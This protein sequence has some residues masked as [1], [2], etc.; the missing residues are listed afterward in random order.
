MARKLRTISLRDSKQVLALMKRE[1][2][3]IYVITPDE[4]KSL[5]INPY[6]TIGTFHVFHDAF[7]QKSNLKRIIDL[8]VEPWT[9]VYFTRRHATKVRDDVGYC[10]F[11]TGNSGQEESHDDLASL[12]RLE[13]YGIP[14]TVLIAKGKRLIS[15]YSHPTYS[16]IKRS[17][18][19]R[20]HED[21]PFSEMRTIDDKVQ[22]V[23]SA[24]GKEQVIYP[25]KK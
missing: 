23:F 8:T 1:M 16:V 18:D 25:A 24:E 17:P 20:V 11:T 14:T 15:L 22:I 12:F 5:A 13:G 19:F 7:T 3:R 2:I 4:F 9:Q 21:L 10:C 6:A